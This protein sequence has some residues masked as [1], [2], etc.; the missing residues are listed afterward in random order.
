MS[1]IV[2][3]PKRTFSFRRSSGGLEIVRARSARFVALEDPDVKHVLA[4][5]DRSGVRGDEVADDFGA[6]L[7]HGFQIQVMKSTRD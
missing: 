5:R 3:A 4:Q 1:R 6:E 7:L 2:L